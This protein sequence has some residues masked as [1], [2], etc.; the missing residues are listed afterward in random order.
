MG[1]LNRAARKGGHVAHYMHDGAQFTLC[2]RYA[3]LSASGDL[4]ACRSCVKLGNIV[5][6]STERELWAIVN[7]SQW[8][9]IAPKFVKAR[10]SKMEL[11]M[12]REVIADYEAGESNH[13]AR[14]A[15]YRLALANT[16]GLSADI[17][18]VETRVSLPKGD[19]M[20]NLNGGAPAKPARKPKH[21]PSERQATLI[22]SL[23][24]QIGEFD[25]ESEKVL[26]EINTEEF[27]N[28][29][30]WEGTK[31]VRSLINSLFKIL[32]TVKNS[33]KE[34][35]ATENVSNAAEDGYYM[36]GDT[37]VCVKWNRAKT[38]QYVQTWN[39][40]WQ[41]WEYDASVSRKLLTRVKAGELPKA[42]MEDAQ[43]FGEL[44]GRCIRCG[45]KL[46]DAKS[47]AQAM[48]K[49]CASKF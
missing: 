8:A 49:T 25:A 14:I 12:L 35:A 27:M 9:D 29:L 47:I 34:K 20:V 10:R 31:S 4:P 46:T 37:F 6:D 26:R 28:E 5:E 19:G 13:P 2:G 41:E 16:S 39:A 32:E 17:R 3:T 45:K 40:E 48:G 30:P 42:T 18:A 11:S 43:R 22:D 36:D 24:R 15:L 23:M 1:T 21:G 44:Y 33:A 7:A 38:G